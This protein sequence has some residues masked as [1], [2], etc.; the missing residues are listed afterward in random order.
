MASKEKVRGQ[1]LFAKFQGKYLIIPETLLFIFD[2]YPKFSRD[3][4]QLCSFLLST[5]LTLNR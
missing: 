3:S 1:S 2:Q 5:H 4:M